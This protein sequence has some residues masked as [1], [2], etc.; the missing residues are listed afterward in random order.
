MK[1]EEINKALKEE[2]KGD[3]KGHR[4]FRGDL[5]IMVNPSVIDQV[6][7][8]LKNDKKLTFN[9][10]ADVCG[11][12]HVKERGCFE[13]VYH[14]LSMKNNIRLRIKTE[15][16]EKN[17]EL[18][19]VTSVF[20]SANWFERETYDMFGIKFL[21]HPD[22]RRILNP[23]NFPGHPLRKDFD[24]GPKDEYCPVPII[25]KT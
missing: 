3:I 17:P 25:K 15:V 5:T 8:F 13:V 12:D 10:L 21:G 6:I 4:E 1:Y 7:G 16:P 9:F 23:E 18:A 19:S 20:R 2:F 22:L 24:G 14:L 11:V